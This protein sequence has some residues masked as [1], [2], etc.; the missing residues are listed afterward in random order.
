MF[1]TKANHRWRSCIFH[2]RN[3]QSFSLPGKLWN[4]LRQYR[5]IWNSKFNLN[6]L[7]RELL[8][9]S[10]VNAWIDRIHKGEAFCFTFLN[11]PQ[12]LL[13]S[14]DMND[15]PFFWYYTSLRIKDYKWDQTWHIE[16]MWKCKITEISKIGKREMTG[17]WNN[18]N[19]RN[20]QNNRYFR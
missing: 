20:K 14:L 2:P 13:F 19:K 8:K 12:R 17:Y 18:R 4:Y 16:N 10:L 15:E 5:K 1:I 7:L 6:W 9:Y 3:F 11:F